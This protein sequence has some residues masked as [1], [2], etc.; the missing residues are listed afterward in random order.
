MSGAL[1]WS[2]V[3]KAE[4]AEQNERIEAELAEHRRRLRAAKAQM[5][6]FVQEVK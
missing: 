5:S 6:L 2:D 1:P 4:I 3:I